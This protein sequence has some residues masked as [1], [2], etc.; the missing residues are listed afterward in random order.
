MIKTLLKDNNEIKF[1]FENLRNTMMSSSLGE[2][3]IKK[4]QSLAPSLP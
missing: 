2:L 4:Y 3:E 1:K